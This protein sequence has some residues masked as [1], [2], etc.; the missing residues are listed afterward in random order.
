MNSRTVPVQSR[1]PRKHADKLKQIA[2]TKG[3]NV[4]L[5]IRILLTKYVEKTNV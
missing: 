3:L 5:F 4:S 2:E 1:L